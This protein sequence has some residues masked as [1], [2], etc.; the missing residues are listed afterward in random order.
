MLGK[1]IVFYNTFGQKQGSKFVLRNA[2]IFSVEILVLKFS[3]NILE[4]VLVAVLDEHE[5]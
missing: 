1:A 3:I 5:I 2:N 4:R